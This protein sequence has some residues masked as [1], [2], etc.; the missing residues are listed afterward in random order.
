MH[1]NWQQKR[2]IGGVADMFGLKVRHVYNVMKALDPE[3]RKLY[4]LYARYLVFVSAGDQTKL[5]H[6]MGEAKIARK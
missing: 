1:K 4:E 3:S 2:I 5:P 6:F